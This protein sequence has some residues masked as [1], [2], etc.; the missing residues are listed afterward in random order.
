M[1]RLAA[2]GDLVGGEQAPGQAKL[3]GLGDLERHLLGEHRS[4]HVAS[5]SLPED[6]ARVLRQQFA[7]ERIEHHRLELGLGLA[8]FV[9]SARDFGQTG[10]GVGR[11]CDRRGN[12]GRRARRALKVGGEVGSRRVRAGKGAEPLGGEARAGRISR[13]QDLH[14]DIGARI[15][16]HG[17]RHW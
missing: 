7:D 15:E 11:V 16:C 14:D 17:R 13:A 9:R 8:G 4:P 2:R 1:R 10:A 5:R 12:C 3:A 6:A